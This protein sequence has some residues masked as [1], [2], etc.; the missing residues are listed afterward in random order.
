MKIFVTKQRCFAASVFTTQDNRRPVV[1]KR[2]DKVADALDK[3]RNKFTL[4][5]V[6][7]DACGGK[8]GHHSGSLKISFARW[9]LANFPML[10]MANSLKTISP[11]FLT[12]FTLNFHRCVL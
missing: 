1:S 12:E 9:P 7:V 11:E 8:R 6:V 5:C 3:D 4:R 2:S 10:R